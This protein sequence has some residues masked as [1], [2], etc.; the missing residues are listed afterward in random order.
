MIYKNSIK[1][2][3]AN[4]KNVWK[5]LLYKL[6]MW[7]FISAICISFGISLIE[8]IFTESILEEFYD[9]FTNSTMNLNIL[10]F[11]SHLFLIV[12]Q[13]F[14]IILAFDFYSWLLLICLIVVATI[15]YFFFNSVL[16]LALSRELSDNMSS[17][18]H[19]G[20]INCVLLSIRDGFK[21]CFVRMLVML[22]LYLLIF[23]VLIKL[24]DL[25]EISAFWSIFAPM[26]FICAAIILFALKMTILLGWQP[27]MI[28]QGVGV[29]KGLKMNFK[30][31]KGKFFK[32]LSTSIF[33]LITLIVL[34]YLAIS[35]LAISIVVT[36]PI[37]TLLVMVYY[38]TAYYH[39][40]GMRY[41]ID[42]NTIE[43]PLKKENTDTIAK[44]KYII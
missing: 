23:F 37:T 29:F 34:N 41:Y 5:I 30:A 16:M 4:F 17:Q 14:N 2:F 12:E 38:M 28:E 44:C 18:T 27:A 42:R 26:L 25:S 9:L 7:L 43:T 8:K 6:I 20:F 19:R 3:F 11:I 35:C 32:L 1:V 24:Y 40:N 21:L 31:L 36:L 10:S 39:C 22:P 33:M 13:M 15:L